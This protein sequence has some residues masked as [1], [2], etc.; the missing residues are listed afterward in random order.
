MTDLGMPV[1]LSLGHMFLFSLFVAVFK[2]S[3][4]SLQGPAPSP[5]LIKPTRKTGR[6]EDKKRSILNS[7]R[8]MNAM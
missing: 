3:S 7:G 5:D 2:G 4:E 6:P 8:A 1:G